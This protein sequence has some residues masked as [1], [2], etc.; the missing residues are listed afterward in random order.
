MAWDDRA[1]ATTVWGCRHLPTRL[2]QE[3]RGS[4]RQREDDGGRLTL[5]T[6]DI[7]CW[8]GGQASGVNMTPAG[9]LVPEMVEIGRSDSMKDAPLR[10]RLRDANDA[11]SYVGNRAGAQCAPGKER[12]RKRSILAYIGL[13][14]SIGDA[15][16]GVVIVNDRAEIRTAEPMVSQGRHPSSRIKSSSSTGFAQQVALAH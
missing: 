4:Y 2:L 1:S 12:P 6:S 5:V 14:V 15:I 7:P 8:N 16:T 9:K 10:Y 11:S 3:G 13:V